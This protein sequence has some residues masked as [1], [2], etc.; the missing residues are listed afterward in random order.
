MDI[1]HDFKIVQMV[2][3]RAKHHLCQSMRKKKAFQQNLNNYVKHVKL[4]QI[5]KKLITEVHR[6]QQTI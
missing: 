2:P 3:D 5:I 4:P 6:V 1:F